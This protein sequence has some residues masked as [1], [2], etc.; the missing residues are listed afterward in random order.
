MTTLAEPVNKS[1]RSQA[2]RTMRG[3]IER[4]VWPAGERVPGE[5]QLCL[6]L[7]V[8]RRTVRAALAHLEAE[9][10]IEGRG[11][12]GRFVLR[13]AAPAPPALL[14]RTAVVVPHS[15]SPVDASIPGGML[16][17]IDMGILD[18]LA[19]GKYRTL[20]MPSSALDPATI[21]E[22]LGGRPL[23]VALAGPSIPAAEIEA[24]ARACRSARV[25]LVTSSQHR[26]LASCD[27][28]LS[29]HRAGGRMLTEWLLQQGCRR[30]LMVLP[31]G[32]EIGWPQDRYRGYCDAMTAAGCE[33]LPR[34]ANVAVACR[35]DNPQVLELRARQYAGFLV[36]HLIGPHRADAIMV[37]SDSDLFP[38]ARAC[39]Y[40]GVDPARDLLLAGYDNY[41][42]T[43]YERKYADFV[44]RITVDKHN[45]QIGQALA[46]LL[47]ARLGDDLPPEPQTRW[48]TPTLAEIRPE[49]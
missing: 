27:R 32:A 42:Q 7:T 31:G 37:P 44:P 43:S 48:I 5:E 29:D 40:C 49:G 9:G 8:S 45:Q 15:A 12:R 26:L 36:E 2:V 39:R 10:L 11:R 14:A 1:P 41:W 38:I 47:L 4:G 19:A 6:N 30:I 3:L 17:A 25:P 46:R 24:L 23:G 33:P 34:L 13:R 35:E 21:A 22:L 18:E 28:V 20:V 16:G